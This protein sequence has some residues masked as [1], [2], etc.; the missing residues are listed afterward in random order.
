MV[1]A[2]AV[3]TLIR[4]YS[5]IRDALLFLAGD[6]YGRVSEVHVIQRVTRLFV[7][8]PGPAGFKVCMSMCVFQ[9]E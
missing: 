1:S 4:D 8:D 3:G 2:E 5:R 9:F 7:A 6:D